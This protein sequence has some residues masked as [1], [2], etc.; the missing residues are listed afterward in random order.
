[1]QKETVS[2]ESVLKPR[3]PPRPPQGD[4]DSGLVQ[5]TRLGG[6]LGGRHNKMQKILGE[7]IEPPTSAVLKPRHNQLQIKA[8]PFV[9]CLVI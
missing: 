7:G 3:Q 4:L 8:K 6:V 2:L 1:M 5:S 9:S